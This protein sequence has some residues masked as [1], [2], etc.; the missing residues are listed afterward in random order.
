V[1]FHWREKFN[2]KKSFQLYFIKRSRWL[3]DCLDI[4]L[5]KCNVLKTQSKNSERHRLNKI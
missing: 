3:I 5:T 2:E 4:A 1:L